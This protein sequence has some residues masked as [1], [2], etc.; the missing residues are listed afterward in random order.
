MTSR[1]YPSICPFCQGKLD[2]VAEVTKDGELTA[3][4]PKDGDLSFCFTCGEFNIFERA[5]PGRLRKPTD[6][7][8][9]EFATDPEAKAIRR[10]WLSV[11][12][13]PR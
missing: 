13:P 11:K 8:Y 9:A 4:V 6:D 3:I 10:A 12:E 5:A 1:A 7:E 2:C